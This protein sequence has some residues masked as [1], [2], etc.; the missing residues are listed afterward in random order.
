[1]YGE[2]PTTSKL[3]SMQATRRPH[4][5]AVDSLHLFNRADG[6]FYLQLSNKSVLA[7]LRSL[8]AGSRGYEKHLSQYPAVLC[9][10]L[11]LLYLF[12]RAACTLDEELLQ[13]LLFSYG[14]REANWG[15][16][17][18]ALAP[19]SSYVVHLQRLRPTLPHG[20]AVIDLAHA[21]SSGEGVAV[22]LAEHWTLLC[23]V[24]DLIA[25]LPVLVS[26][27][28]VGPTVEEEALLKVEM[29]AVRKAYKK[30]GEAEA[31]RAMLQQHLSLYFR[32]HLEW[33]RGREYHGA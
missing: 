32:S 27:L 31:R 2:L 19:R 25:Q 30:G 12:R 7:R 26:P 24:R 28:R 1:M 9:A 10:P 20:T 15:A 29:D 4:Y 8:C 16:W 22:D 13:D 17:L 21:A 33:A 14:W 11:D 18:A 5:W 3:G 23:E 6:P